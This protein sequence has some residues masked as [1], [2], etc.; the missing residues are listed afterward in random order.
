MEIDIYYKKLKQEIETKQLAKELGD[1]KEQIFTRYATDLLKQKDETDNVSVAYDSETNSRKNPHKINAFA[2]DDSSQTLDLFVTIYKVGAKCPAISEEEVKK[3]S[4]EITS[5]YNKASQNDY[6][7]KIAESSEIFDC[8]NALAYDESLKENLSNIRIF[9]LTNGSYKGDSLPAT[10]ID[11]KQVSYKIV[12]INYLY[13]LSEDANAPIVV[14][15]IQRG[16]KNV[17]CISAGADNDTYQA[18]LAIVP[19]ALIADLYGDFKTRLMENNVRQFL[20]STGK[21]NKGIKDTIINKPTMFLAYNNGIAATASSIELDKS[22]RYIT[23]IEDFQIVNGGQTTAS[24]F[25][26]REENPVVNLN[27]VFVQVKLS[28]IKKKSQFKEIVESISRCANMQNKVNEADFYANDP[29]LIALE[30]LSRFM[31]VDAN[32]NNQTSSYWFFERT[33]GQY[34][35]MRIKDGFTRT[36]E[37]QFDLKYPKNQMFTKYDL[38]KYINS[39]DLVTECATDRNGV[40]EVRYIV[41]PHSVCKGNEKNYEFYRLR[42]LPAPDKI[43]NIYFED[44]I[45]KAIIFQDADRRYGTKSGNHIGDIKK[46]VVPYTIALLRLL[47]D[48]KINLYKI[49]LNQC[50]SDELSDFIYGMMKQVDA[51]IMEMSPDKRYEEWGKKEDC[52]EKIKAH[53]WSFNLNKI[54]KD[55]IDEKNPPVRK[56]LTQTEDEEATAAYNRS[57]VESIPTEIWEKTYIWGEESGL[58]NSMQKIACQEIKRK[59]SLGQELTD[60]EVNR[61]MVIADLLSKN[62]IDLLYESGSFTEENLQTPKRTTI[63][64][65]EAKRLLSAPDMIQQMLEFNQTRN[66]LKEYQRKQL[67]SA[68]DG[69][70]TISRKAII[71]LAHCYYDLIAKG[72]K[73]TK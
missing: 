26:T 60:E 61:G 33:K 47:T 54:K 32:K 9:I 40:N 69:L 55:L 34:K 25:Y 57:Y 1:S 44:L 67:Q 30:K 46:T 63:D 53:E 72:F 24:L 17:A 22:G 5:F 64:F 70:D 35:N 14:D 36:R 58:L 15:F 2:I 37:R 43:T 41:G 12:D 13:E 19:G 6:A 65:K 29:S 62:N 10:H 42:N 18:Y 27:K 71:G 52:W 7:L 3:A 59:L 49:W 4:A 23:K 21:V 56:L 31:M 11:E 28:V 39:Y 50:L 20:Q 38:A 73:Y 68:V 66:Y 51:F 8:A 16:Y 45:A 48:N